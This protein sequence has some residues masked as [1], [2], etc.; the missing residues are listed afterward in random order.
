MMSNKKVSVIRYDNILSTNF[1]RGLRENPN[2]VFVS[3]RMHNLFR[4][5]LNTT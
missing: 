2:F 1:D 3:E 4:T 5:W